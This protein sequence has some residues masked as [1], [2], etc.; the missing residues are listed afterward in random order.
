MKAFTLDERTRLLEAAPRFMTPHAVGR[1]IEVKGE[2][3]ARMAQRGDI[4]FVDFGGGR[5]RIP[6]EE[7]IRLITPIHANQGNQTP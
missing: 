7:V 1:L 3:V 4:A 2:T 6:K 5:I